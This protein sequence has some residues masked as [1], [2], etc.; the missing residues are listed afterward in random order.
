M[1]LAVVLA[2]WALT[3]PPPRPETLPGHQSLTL[4]PPHRDVP[5]TLHLWYPAEQD[6]TPGLI[7]HNALFIGTWKAEAA[8]PQPGAHPL[9]LFS[10]GSGGNAER[11][12]WFAS[13][14]AEKGFVVAAPNHPGTTSRDSDPFQTPMVWQRTADLS[15]TLDRL[16]T[17]P[18]TGLRIDATNI[19]SAGFSLGGHSALALGGARLSKAAFIAY[20]DQANDQFDCGWMS[21][22][23]VDFSTI[24]AA[25]YEADLSDPRITGVIAI[26]PALTPAMTPISL[27]QV[28]RPTLILNLGTSDTLPLALNAA[29][30]AARIHNASYTALPGARHF[31]FLA[32]CSR[33]GQI[34]IGLAG[35]DNICTD[36]TLRPRAQVHA[37]L[38]SAALNFLTPP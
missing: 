18:P 4:T 23:G 13:A 20:C 30:A 16:L 38:L 2:G 7:G 10:H 11:L 14:L 22:A 19:T 1:A 8:T 3:L 37:D 29:P 12:G 17:N 35:E 27:N 5:V 26:D 15:A 28:T 25:R 33:L 24:D 31:S 32:P 36:R 9:V 21:A 6:G 34:I